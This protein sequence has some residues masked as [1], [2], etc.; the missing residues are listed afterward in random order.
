MNYVIYEN[1]PTTTFTLH[2]SSC[3]RYK[4]RKAQGTKNGN[5]CLFSS[6]KL[7]AYLRL[8][9]IAGIMNA[10]SKRCKKCKP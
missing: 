8:W 2:K 4:K 1:Y 5:W 6:K 10:K 9:A 7:Q 3:K